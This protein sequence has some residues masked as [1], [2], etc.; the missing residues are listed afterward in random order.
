MSTSLTIDGVLIEA[1]WRRYL[2]DTLEEPG[3]AEHW[4]IESAE[5]VNLKEWLDSQDLD[6]PPEDVDQALEYW[7]DDQYEDI[8]DCFYAV[9]EDDLPS[10]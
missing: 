5:I 3:H 10:R 9:F 8:Q 1:I 4:E 2:P 6:D 7:L